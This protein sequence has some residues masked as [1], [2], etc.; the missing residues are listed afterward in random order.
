MC[1]LNTCLSV[2]LSVVPPS[3]A[4]AAA[5]AAAQNIVLQQQQ[6]ATSASLGLSQQVITNAHGQ[7]VAIG[8][9]QVTICLF[10]WLVFTDLSAAQ[11]T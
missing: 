9:A 4:T 8:A 3:A 2:C 11:V 5:A 1:K 10:L 6:A 7:I